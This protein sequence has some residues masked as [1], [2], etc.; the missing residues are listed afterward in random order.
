MA[1]SGKQVG[2][3]A[4]SYLEVRRGRPPAFYGSGHST[5]K[6]YAAHMSHISIIP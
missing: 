3:R 5:T 6:R 4:L 1:A 2:G